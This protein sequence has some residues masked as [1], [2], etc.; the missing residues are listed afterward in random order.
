MTKTAKT[1]TAKPAK[2]AKPHGPQ[3]EAY[4]N[5]VVCAKR[6]CK[7]VRWTKPQDAFQVKFCGEHQAEASRAKRLAKAKS[8]RAAAK[9]AVAS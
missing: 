5:R 2:K 6:G 3:G 1:P 9:A 7:A 8:R 4:T